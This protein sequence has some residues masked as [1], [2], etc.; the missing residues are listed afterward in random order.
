MKI[1]IDE[2]CKRVLGELTPH[3]QLSLRVQLA[4]QQTHIKKEN[5]DSAN[6]LLHFWREKG[7]RKRKKE[8][9]CSF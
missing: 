5:Y 2:V 9:A 3:S 6:F 7:E 4:F 1:L 8:R